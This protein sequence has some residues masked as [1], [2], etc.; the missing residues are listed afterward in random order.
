MGIDKIY[1]GGV[2]LNKSE[3]NSTETK[4]VKDKHGNEETVYIVNFKNGVKASYRGGENSPSS[5][6]YISATTNDSDA[7]AHTNVYDVFGLELH[8][9]SNS[10]D[11][12]SIVGGSIVGV[13]V[14]NDDKTDVVNITGTDVHES[15]YGVLSNP[16]VYD[17]QVLVNKQDKTSILQAGETQA[18][19]KGYAIGPNG[20][21]I[22][23]IVWK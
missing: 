9:N 17:G 2:K 5:N 19:E 6:S 15:S 1:F 14:S 22:H 16:P 13:D 4:I 20:L 10:G 23:R 12:I 7:F 21:G 3:V 11:K 8:G 18:T